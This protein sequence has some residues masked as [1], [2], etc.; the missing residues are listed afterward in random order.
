MALNRSE[1]AAETTEITQF[2]RFR[3]LLF[4]IYHHFIYFF[5]LWSLLL[6]S[7]LSH[8][9]SLLSLSLHHFRVNK[10]FLLFKS[11]F[12]SP[13]ESP[14]LSKDPL[15]TLY[16]QLSPINW[17][18]IPLWLLLQQLKVPPLFGART[19]LLLL[20]DLLRCN[21]NN[22]FLIFLDRI[23]SFFNVFEV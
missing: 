9:F 3:F 20:Y 23:S 22:W 1:D 8:H 5:F 16:L 11:L 4:L 12:L 13:T 15:H 14:T 10:L 17:V 18:R 19:C 21:N 6:Q 2:C 7:L